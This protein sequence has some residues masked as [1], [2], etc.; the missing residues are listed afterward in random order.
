[1]KEFVIYSIQANILLL[2]SFLLYRMLLSNESSFKANRAYLI[3]SVILSL[4]IPLINTPFFFKS[5]LVQV[6]LG[7]VIIY[8]VGSYISSSQFSYSK[9]LVILYFSGLCIAFVG[10]LKNLLQIASLIF[11]GTSQKGKGYVLVHS[12][13]AKGIFSFLRFII[14]P[15]EKQ[16]TDNRIIEHELTHI[17]QLHS[18]DV[19]FF[20][21]VSIL[22]WYNPVCYLFKIAIKENHEFLAD[23]AVV[24]GKDS[25]DEY[26]KLITSYALDIS[27]ES[28]SGNFINHSFLR[29][30]IIMLGKQSSKAKNFAIKYALTTALLLAVITLSSFFKDKN[31]VLYNNHNHVYSVVDEMPKF[32]GNLQ[33]YL[34]KSIKYPTRAKAKGITGIVYVRFVI[35]EEGNVSNATI[36]KGPDKDL[37][38]EA[39]RVISAMPAWIPGKNKGKL[40]SVEFNLPIDFE[41]K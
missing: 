22:F 27:P 20:E 26:A 31:I 15:S 35:D 6:N 7:E 1:M 40:V 37:D 2:A 21:L 19:L 17:R 39:I 28:L 8:K 38:A 5:L 23:D 24:K 18:L 3:I 36:L 32:P 29:R 34:S 30:R 13:K 16:Y 41:L 11:K 4:F 14:I 25:R 12:K 33:E 9:L 10:F